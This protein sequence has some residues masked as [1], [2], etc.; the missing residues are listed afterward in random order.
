MESLVRHLNELN[1]YSKV[2]LERQ[3]KN[4]NI[5]HAPL[6][7]QKERCTF[8][9]TMLPRARNQDFFG[10]ADELARIDKYLDYRGNTKL[11]TYTIYG[12]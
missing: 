1:S 3:V 10:R 11:R 9:V 2:N 6:S 8:P 4:L 5:R 7:L 12:R